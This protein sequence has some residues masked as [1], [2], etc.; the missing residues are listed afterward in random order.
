MAAPLATALTLLGG[1]TLYA[2]IHSLFNIYYRPQR[3][4]YVYFALMCLFGCFYIYSRLNN[5]HSLSIEN[6][7]AVQRWG[8]FAAQLLFLSQIG[9]ITEYAQWRPRWIITVLVSSMLALLII[10]LILPYGLAHSSPFKLQHFSLPWGET[11]TD[12]R[13]HDKTLWWDWQWL[14]IIGVFAF[15]FAAAF[16][17][18]TTGDTKRGNALLWFG[19]I[20]FATIL[21]N[22]LINFYVVNFTQLAEFGLVA[23]ITL[24]SLHLN[25]EA[26]STQLRAES[27]EGTW[28]S[29][30]MNAPNVILLIDRN[31]IIRFVNRALVGNDSEHVIGTS[32]DEHL[33]ADSQAIMHD[34][35]QKVISNK[36]ALGIQLQ[37]ND[38]KNSWMDVQLAPLLVADKLEHIIVMATD[39][40]GQI[41]VRNKLQRSEA[42]YR[43]LLQTL[44]YGV[45]EIDR[46]GNIT[47]SNPAHDLLF[48]YAPG[49]MLGMSIFELP[50]QQA[51]VDR[52]RSYIQY[53]LEKQPAPQTYYKQGHRKNGEL[54]EIKVDWDYRYDEQGHIIGM[55]SV[56]TD[57]TQQHKAEQALRNS[58][59]KFRQLAENIEQVFFIRDLTSNRMLYVSPAYETIW[60]RSIKEIYNNPEDF[61]TSIHPDDK[62]NVLQLLRQQNQN[63]Q[64]FNAEYRIIDTQGAV[65]WIHARSYPVT[66]ETGKTQRIAGIVDDITQRKLTEQH[67]QIRTRELK[68]AHDFTE[69]IVDTVGAV[70][71]VLDRNGVIVRFN[72]ACEYISGYSSEEA[73]GC[74]IW[75]FLILPEHRASIKQVFSHLTIGEFPNH[76]ENY[77]LHK[78]GSKRLI[79]WSN[80]CLTD[81]TGKV[82][83]VIG[84]GVDITEQR[85]VEAA[86][87][88]SAEKYRTLMKHASDIILIA[89]LDGKLIECNSSALSVLKY[90]REELLNLHVADIHPDDQLE[91]TKT[92]FQSLVETGSVVSNDNA[93]LCRDG[94][95]I[96]VDINANIIEYHGRKVAVGFLRDIRARKQI[97]QE[98]LQ[99]ELRQREML[100][101]EVHHRIKNNLQG[102]IGLLRNSL[103]SET[104]IGE[105]SERLIARAITQIATIAIVHGLQ[106]HF[107]QGEVRICEIT[108]AIVDQSRGFAPDDIHLEFHMNVIRPALLQ[109]TEAIPL[110]LVI[111]ELLTNAIKHIPATTTNK[112]VIVELKGSPVDGMELLVFN[113]GTYQP[114]D[115]KPEHGKQSGVGLDL[116]HALLPK[117]HSCFT[118]TEEPAAGGV[119]ARLRIEPALLS[120]IIAATADITG[121]APTIN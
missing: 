72:H 24:M 115:R 96:P 48:G 60:G 76:Y 21:S 30:V 44:P 41:A 82:E 77:W 103:S 111:N 54:F 64:L 102:V 94:Q 12:T 52:L 106:S 73:I 99:A 66:D 108:R 49:Q 63:G 32:I 83:Y 15:Q 120:E 46:L 42:K 11:I 93:V 36:K 80:T 34:G 114:T 1:F 43:Q 110:A 58:E 33:H 47:F 51:E 2:A 14:T 112:Q 65:H 18:R 59:E 116:I 55:I 13:I 3:R 8:F 78:N 87:R 53:I 62:T 69:A 40:T 9:F 119:Y 26:R 79:A 37:L 50:A 89:D 5:L 67:L 20:F 105:Q 45:Q 100:V 85:R 61:I 97:E 101:R 22:L 35:L 86:L 25:R 95:V 71:V 104:D 23:M 121:Q 4:M 74:A 113:S 28:S 56:L 70:I 27:A 98:R 19:G 90:S 117:A 10:N 29:L 57:I 91:R 109:E 84:T 118:L 107:S 17:L 88:D 75:D 7:I 31:G 16:H 68:E 39:I 92:D 6:F 81:Q 38:P